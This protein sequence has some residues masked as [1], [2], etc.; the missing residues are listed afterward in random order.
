MGKGL[1]DKRR[2]FVETY[3]RCWNATQSALAAGYS[4]RTAGSQGHDLLK[5]PEIQEEVRRRLEELT[6]SEAEVLTRITEHARG[7]I[8]QY[9]KV[10]EEWTRYPLPSYDVIDAKEVTEP[11]EY[12]ANGKEVKKAETYTVWWVRHVAVNM[13]RFLEPQYSRLVKKFSDSPKDGI[14]IE[15]YDAQAALK[16]LAQKYG[17]LREKMEVT[18]KDGEPIRVIEVVKDYG[19]GGDRKGQITTESTPGAN[20]SLG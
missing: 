9:F 7:D 4:E 15:L 17:M 12:D 20:T 13:D 2:V 11:A 3:V 1:S 10:V 14:S 19:T 8:G 18:G 16:M 5:K 6:M